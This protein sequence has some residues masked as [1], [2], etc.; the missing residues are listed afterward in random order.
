MVAKIQTVV[1]DSAGFNSFDPESLP[2]A[3]T[4]DVNGN[5]TTVTVFAGGDS[6][7]KTS[8]WGQVAGVWQRQSVS[9]WVPA[10]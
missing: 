7:V 9:G 3:F 5:L 4:Y 10:T 1:T 8:V 2:Q 6:W